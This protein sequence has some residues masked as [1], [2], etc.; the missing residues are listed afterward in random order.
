MSDIVA[1]LASPT[2]TP[3]KEDVLR[4]LTPEIS[5]RNGKYG[6]YIH[7]QT[8][9]MKKP[10][11]YNIKKFKESYRYCAEDVLLAWIKETYNIG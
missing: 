8:K 4:F 7:H 6:A 2:T 5:V 11:F 1:A 9:D 10:A 3:K